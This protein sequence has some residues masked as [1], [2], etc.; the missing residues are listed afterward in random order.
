ML[1]EYNANLELTL[2]SRGQSGKILVWSIK[3]IS[4][5]VIEIKHGFL[6]GTLTTTRAN[7]QL[8]SLEAEI[9]SRLT[10]QRRQGYKTIAE[11]AKLN[12]L[13]SDY[14]VTYDLINNLLP[15]TNLDLNYNLKPMKAQSYRK[16]KPKFPYLGQCK[17]NGIR[18]VARKEEVSDGIGLFKSTS[19]EIV[20]R[21]MEGLEYLIPTA[22][23]EALINSL[24]NHIPGSVPIALDGEIYA[25][26]YGLNQINSAIPKR[27]DSGTI[28]DGDI[29][30]IKDK[31][32]FY[33]FDLAMEGISQINRVLAL[34]IA[35]PYSFSVILEGA[36]NLV[37][38]IANNIVIVNSFIINNDE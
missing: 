37:T 1:R 14:I 26:G 28:S 20:V 27:Y 32:K 29:Y 13:S 22:D 33:V 30:N 19:N 5:S 31:L 36:A 7:V 35:R 24:D 12:G 34:T 38:T 25:H 11:L 18:A 16:A 21:S 8:T 10:S 4:M 15:V 23:I 2:Y 6:L 3:P 17:I 9:R